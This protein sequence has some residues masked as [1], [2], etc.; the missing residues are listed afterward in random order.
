MEFGI[1]IGLILLY[2]VTCWLA[3]KSG[4]RK[5]LEEFAVEAYMRELQLERDFE[6]R[7]NFNSNYEE[8]IPSLLRRQAE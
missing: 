2:I 3:Y 7:M 8:N 4:Y 5:G 6:E 1:V